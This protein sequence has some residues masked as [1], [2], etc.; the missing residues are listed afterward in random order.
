MDKVRIASRGE[1][2][3][4]AGL[5]FTREGQVFGPGELTPEQVEVLAREPNLI[6]T[7]VRED[8]DTGEATAEGGADAK[9]KAKR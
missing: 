3:R 2:F 6:I 4:R 1:F 5:G 8:A 9:P 7:P